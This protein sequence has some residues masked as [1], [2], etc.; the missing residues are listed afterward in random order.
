MRRLA[1]DVHQL[2]GFPPN[3]MNVYLVDG[4]LVDA[5]SPARAAADP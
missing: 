2:R 4:V 5:A 1:P 3:V